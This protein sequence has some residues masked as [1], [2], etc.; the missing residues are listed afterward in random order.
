M[1]ESDVDAE[2]VQEKVKEVICKTIT[3]I[4]LSEVI[5]KEC[6]S[7]TVSKANIIIMLL[8]KENFD[9]I[10]K[11]VVINHERDTVSGLSITYHLWL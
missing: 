5:S 9:G 2:E 11:Y 10:Y 3:N 8:F 6:F 4:P 1:Q 7:E